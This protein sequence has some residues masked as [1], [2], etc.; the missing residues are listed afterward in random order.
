LIVAPGDAL[1]DGNAKRIDA[2]LPHGGAA[3]EVGL[4]EERP[5]RPRVGFALP[6]PKQNLFAV[7]EENERHIGLFCVMSALLAGIGGIDTFALGFNGGQATPLAPAKQ[8]VGAVSIGRR[9]FMTDADAIVDPTLIL[10]LG[11]DESAGEGFG[12]R[13]MFYFLIFLNNTC[14]ARFPQRRQRL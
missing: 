1:V 5:D 2:H 14:S 4:R 13:Y 3:F 10:E 6:V 12:L 11:V 8:V 7:G 9:V